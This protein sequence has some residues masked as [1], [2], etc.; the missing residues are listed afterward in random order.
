MTSHDETY[1]RWTVAF[2]EPR[3]S[4]NVGYVARVMANF[5][6]RDLVIV[7][8]SKRLKPMAKTA[9]KYSSHGHLIL[10]S[11][12]VLK[13]LE[14]LRREKGVLAATT[15]QVA[16]R[17]S[18]IERKALSPEEFAEITLSRSDVAL[19]LG[20]DTTGLTNEELAMCD[21]VVHVQTW[22][23]YP[24][25][26]I[27]HALA[28]ILYV[29]A[30]RARSSG[31]RLRHWEPPRPE[32]IKALEGWVLKATSKLGYD[33]QRTRKVLLSIRRLVT[34]SMASRQEVR[35]LLGLIRQLVVR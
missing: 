14:E 30:N 19:V 6:L 3:F 23:D 17:P 8:G 33:G 18:K 11:S 7:T 26:N 28:I 22:S 10:E 31:R 9:I 15:A 24:T 21:V 32:E 12:R 1:R 27:S 5:G 16:R 2:V 13:T 29:V 4:M 25:L 20:R 35:V 34:T